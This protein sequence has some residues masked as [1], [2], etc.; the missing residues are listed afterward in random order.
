MDKGYIFF[1]RHG[2]TDWNIKRLMQGRDEIPLNE[3]GISQ[4]N[5]AAQ[6]FKESSS[7]SGVHFDRVIT[8]P[9]SRASVTGKAIADAIG[10]TDFSTD[11]RIIERDFGELSG[12]PYEFS[13]PYIVGDADYVKGLEPV[14]SVLERVDSFIKEVVKPNT[15]I[16]AVTHGSVSGVFASRSKKRDGVDPTGKILH[17]CHMVVYSYDG[18]EIIMEGYDISPREIGSLDLK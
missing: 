10:C 9:L 15:N 6:L 14:C 2:Q 3:V 16:I 5:E 1:V 13:A 17:N 4:A 11:D 8:S 12:K 18:N 7:K